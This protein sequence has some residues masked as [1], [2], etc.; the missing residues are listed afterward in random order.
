MAHYA[1]LREYHFSGDVYDIRG[2]RVYGPDQRQ[3]GKVVDVVF[4]HDTGGIEGLVVDIGRSR[5]VLLSSDHL[6]RSVLDE[7]DFDTD[8]DRTQLGGLP[9]F[10]E[11]HLESESNWKEFQRR[12]HDAHEQ[13]EKRLEKEFKEK[14]EKGP[15]E[16][17]RGS[18]RLI[19]PNPDEE[20]AVPSASGEPQSVDPSKLWP[21]RLVS[22]FPDTAP[23]PEKVR[24]RPAGI[25]ADAED[26]ARGE[27]E[28][29]RWIEFQETIRE[30]LI[31]IRGGCSTCK[32]ERKTA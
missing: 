9:V 15:V 22:K 30:N 19:T 29:P 23:S 14:L 4:E 1:T 8:L 13:E 26:A 24:L 16:H 2:A 3:V 21:E 12:L 20:P 27:E 17:R 32:Q 18:D 5:K 10:D 7:D 31:S 11:K 6:F 25:A 28:A